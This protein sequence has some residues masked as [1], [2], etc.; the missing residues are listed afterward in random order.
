MCKIQT[1]CVL[2][3]PYCFEQSFVCKVY[4]INSFL[5][6]MSTL[7]FG[8]LNVCVQSYKAYNRVVS[9]AMTSHH[10]SWAHCAAHHRCIHCNDLSVCDDPMSCSMCTDVFPTL[11]VSCCP[12]SKP[13]DAFSLPLPLH[14]IT[15]HAHCSPMNLFIH[16]SFPPI[17]PLSSLPPSIPTPSVTTHLS[18]PASAVQ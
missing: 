13:H 4:K 10:R 5:G 2:G 9:S 8:S 7:S 11:A 15:F 16:V 18:N 6:F 17:I 14:Y 1:L 3:G 12:V